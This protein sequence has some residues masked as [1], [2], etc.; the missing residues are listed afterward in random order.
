MEFL[1]ALG[2][3]TSDL[4]RGFRPIS[5]RLDEL[6]RVCIASVGFEIVSMSTN[7]VSPSVFAVCGTWDCVV[8]GVVGSGQV[9][10]RIHVVAAR[11]DRTEQL[12]KAIW[13]PDSIN[14]LAL[15]TTRSV[16]VGQCSLRFTP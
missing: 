4:V 14:L 9:C 13:L 3:G 5:V 8:L 16:Q 7:P 11:R 2:S 6:P 15:L 1:T 10:G 12:I